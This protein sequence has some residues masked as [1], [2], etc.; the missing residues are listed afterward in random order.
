MNRRQEI[1]ATLLERRTSL[2]ELVDAE[3]HW[4]DGDRA[5]AAV[6]RTEIR[7]LTERQA[8][9]VDAGEDR[10]EDRDEQVAEEGPE[11]R[12]MRQLRDG[13]TLTGLMSA[14]IGGQQP[15][16]EIRELQQH[17]QIDANQLPLS[18]LDHW[19]GQHVA[20]DRAR[21]PVGDSEAEAST[22]LIDSVLAL[23]GA[24]FLGI[25][26]E[27]VPP[28]DRNYSYLSTTA[29]LNF[30][31]VGVTIGSYPAAAAFTSVD[32][33]PR[34]VQVGIEWSIEDTQRMRGLERFCQRH[35]T[36]V[37]ATGV[38]EVVIDKLN[39]SSGGLTFDDVNATTTYELVKAMLSGAVDGV[40]AGSESGMRF[41][42]NAT[43]F[44]F[45]RG[46]H[47][48]AAT[49]SD[50]EDAADTIA[51]LT[52]AMPM[53]NAKMPAAASSKN[54]V[55]IALPRGMGDSA[56]LAQWGG[57]TVIPDNISGAASRL[58]RVSIIGLVACALVRADGFQTGLI[59]TN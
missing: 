32:E 5:R 57:L 6:L 49:V 15:V 55:I 13:F 23:P 7:A 2:G 26:R 48:V 52:G 19:A 54:R 46:L 17:E 38:D 28:G 42:T 45:L 29:A 31:A 10:P 12:E 24:D 53:V 36:Q 21:T 37:Y 35:A 20:E 30:P 51:R 33:S 14:V 16:G 3:G 1:E 27:T 59:Q 4:T 25:R 18:M 22:G 8:A 50:S 56:R 41:M 39:A 44:S 43:G 40:Y 47:Q 9:A 58:V 11:D 34:A